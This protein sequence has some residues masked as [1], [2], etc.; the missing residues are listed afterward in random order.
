MISLKEFEDNI[1]KYKDDECNKM[2]DKK[3][4]AGQPKIEFFSYSTKGGRETI[5]KYPATSCFKNPKY[6]CP[7]FSTTQK[8]MISTQ[9]FPDNKSYGISIDAN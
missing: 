3:N 2:Q 5:Q 9:H 1:S 6:I 7:D 8:P 4:Q